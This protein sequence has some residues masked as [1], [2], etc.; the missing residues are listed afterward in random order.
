MRDLFDYFR[1]RD[2]A[3]KPFLNADG[4]KFFGEVHMIFTDGRIVHTR[5]W[6]TNDVAMVVESKKV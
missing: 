4:K 2:A 6:Q 1:K 5:D 3:G